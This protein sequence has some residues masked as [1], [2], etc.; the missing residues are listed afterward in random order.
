MHPASHHVLMTEWFWRSDVGWELYDASICA[1]LN[2]ASSKQRVKISA[3]HE[4]D[5]EEMKQFRIGNEEK[6][7]DVRKQPKANS[8]GGMDGNRKSSI[9]SPSRAEQKIEAVP[10]V[11]EFQWYWGSDLGWIPYGKQ[12]NLLLEAAFPTGE[13]VTLGRYLIDIKQMR[14]FRVDTPRKAR[15]VSRVTA[16]QHLASWIPTDIQHISESKLILGESLGRGPFSDV[17]KAQWKP[18][19]SVCHIVAVKQYRWSILRSDA[20]REQFLQEVSSLRYLQHNNIIRFHGICRQPGSVQVVLD[21]FPRNLTRVIESSSISSWHKIQL[22][23]GVAKGMK[24]LHQNKITHGNLKPANIL[25][26][27]EFNVK[28]CDFRFSKTMCTQTSSS[29]SESSNEYKAPENFKLKDNTDSAQDVYSFGIVLWELLQGYSSHTNKCNGVSMSD[30]IEPELKKLAELGNRCLSFDPQ[31]RP[32][33]QIIVELLEK[34]AL[35]P[36]DKYSKLLAQISKMKASDN[37]AQEQAWISYGLLQPTACQQLLTQVMDMQAKYPG[38]DVCQSEKVTGLEYLEALANSTCDK[39]HELLEKL[40]KQ[41]GGDYFKGPRKDLSY[42]RIKVSRDYQNNFRRL[43]D[44][45][46]ASGVF[47]SV[48]SL[49]TVLERIFD[50][51]VSGLVLKRCKDRLNNPR[52]GYRDILLNFECNGFIGELQLTLKKLWEYKP[53]THRVLELDRVSEA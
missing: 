29:S 40:V 8:Q 20:R 42:C 19:A 13:R 26:D 9:K 37:I 53:L 27:D 52:D 15:L 34:C 41:A 16:T 51:K 6:R 17:R 22:A 33:F 47:D 39:F 36:A 43:L 3:K 4:V 50:N 12:D 44:F 32:T 10:L 23:L 35:W 24:F 11:S 38:T 25:V 7:R 46:R 18:T 45:E 48:S 28:I 31:Q 2:S 1:K 21:Y 30:Q 49:L 14:Q 5:L